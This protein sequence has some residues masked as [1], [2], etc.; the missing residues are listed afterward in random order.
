MVAFTASSS[1]PIRA[2]TSARVPSRL[3]SPGAPRVQYD[4]ASEIPGR[5]ASSPVSAVPADATAGAPTDPLRAV[6]SS[7]RLGSPVWKRSRSSWTARLESDEGS[8]KPP[9]ERWR[10]TDPPTIPATGRKASAGA[11]TQRR[12]RVTTR[13]SHR[14]PAVLLSAARR[15]GPT[16]RPRPRGG[17]YDAKVRQHQRPFAEHAILALRRRRTGRRDGTT[18]RRSDGAGGDAGRPLP[19]QPA[20]VCA[21]GTRLPP[22]R[23]RA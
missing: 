8:S 3:R 14:T 23:R 4:A 20:G 17:G 9:A 12:R 7:T 13:P 15:S 19:P 11:I 5:A 2:S 21:R 1:P 22:P 6:T 16:D 10:S 18:A